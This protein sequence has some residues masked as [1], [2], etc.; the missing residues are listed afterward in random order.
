[1]TELRC[2]DGTVV[3]ISAETEKELRKA[4]EKS[5]V[6]YQI[7]DIFYRDHDK[8]EYLKLAFGDEGRVGLRITTHSTCAVNGYKVIQDINA[9]TMDEV[10]SMT[11]F[12]SGL[13]HITEF[14]VTE[15]VVE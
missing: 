3:P 12:S 7:G 1:M 2:D 8:S 13:R 4:F 14:I 6:T 9:I 5:K 15:I 11:L 10:R